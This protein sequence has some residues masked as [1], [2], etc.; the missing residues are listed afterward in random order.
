[1]TTKPI[2]FLDMDGVL[3]NRLSLKRAQEG[4]FPPGN[5]RLSTVDPTCVCRLKDF[6][7]DVDAEI[8]ISSSWRSRHMDQD[9]WEIRPSLTSGNASV[10][11][12]LRWCGWSCHHLL[13]GNTAHLYDSPRGDE[14]DDWLT[15]HRERYVYNQTS[16]LI[17]DDCNDFSEIQ[18]S[19]HLVRTNSEYGITLED[20][21]KARKL[22]ENQIASFNHKET[23]V[24]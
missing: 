22:L 3:N 2:I 23:N 8:V 1:M 6:V 15:K 10:L 13:I 14:I 16:Y 12:A 17:F 19:K 18:L 9:D 5:L 20:I 11:N 21:A 7:T 24:L 4:I